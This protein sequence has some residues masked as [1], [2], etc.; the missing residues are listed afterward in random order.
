MSRLARPRAECA[1]GNSDAERLACGGV[2]C[3]RYQRAGG[4][5]LDDGIAARQHRAGIERGQVPFQ[6]LN[7]RAV[8]FPLVAQ[9]ALGG[10]Q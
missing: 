5:V 4:G 2:G 6:R 3:A 7:V 8:Q 10:M 1:I 9:R